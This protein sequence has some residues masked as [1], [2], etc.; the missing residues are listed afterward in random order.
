MSGDEFPAVTLPCLRSNTGE[1]FAYDSIFESRR[2][3]LSSA[4]GW[5]NDGGA[6]TAGGARRG[7]AELAS[8]PTELA[9][10]REDHARAGGG[11]GMADGDARANRI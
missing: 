8:S 3:T 9:R 5:S 4:I 11:E 1:S 6:E 7:E 2:T 10:E